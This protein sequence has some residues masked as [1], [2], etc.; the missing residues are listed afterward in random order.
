M[1]KFLM[2]LV[3]LILG[4][5]ARADTSPI[6]IWLTESGSGQV[7]I[8]PCGTTLCGKI[9]W[10]KEPLTDK[11]EPK[12]DGNNPNEAQRQRPILGLAML[13]GFAPATSGGWDG[14][15]IYNP[16]DGKTYKCVLALDDPDRLRVRGYV[17]IPLLGKT[18]IWTRVR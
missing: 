6:G 15:T 2:V 8:A 5:A 11:G 1:R 17:G 14:G 12:T 18:Q 13:E 4:T 7:E 16:E 10:L 9:V 3:A